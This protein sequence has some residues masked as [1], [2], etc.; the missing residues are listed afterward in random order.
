[1]ESTTADDMQLSIDA[2]MHVLTHLSPH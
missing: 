2:L 1:L